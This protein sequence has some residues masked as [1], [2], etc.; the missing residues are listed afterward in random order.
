MNFLGII[1][2][3]KWESTW[4]DWEIIK[5]RSIRYILPYLVNF[6]IRYLDT[7]KRADI[8]DELLS[9][10]IKPPNQ[11]FIYFHSMCARASYH[12]HKNYS[13]SYIT[14][15]LFNGALPH[16][17]NNFNLLNNHI[18]I[19]F[20]VEYYYNPSDHVLNVLSTIK[21]TIETTYHHIP[22]LNR[23]ITKLSNINKIL[24]FFDPIGLKYAKTMHENYS[25]YE[26]QAV[27]YEIGE[28]MIQNIK[29]INKGVNYE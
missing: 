22:F 27:G 5:S 9:E 26:M 1:Y 17:K 20:K 16:L 11:A 6:V 23:F 8:A 4:K 2:G 25:L 12:C 19:S 21:L 15:I 14:V 10:N 18:V 7:C 13:K 29:F 3:L 24:E 28:L